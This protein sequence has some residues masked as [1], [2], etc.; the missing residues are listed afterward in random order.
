MMRPS[1]FT[2]LKFD[3]CTVAACCLY[4]SGKFN[5]LQVPGLKFAASKKTN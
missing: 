2:L 1:K 3:F 5:E 4:V